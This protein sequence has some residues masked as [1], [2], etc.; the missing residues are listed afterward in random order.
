MSVRIH[1]GFPEGWAAA[2]MFGGVG[3]VGGGDSGVC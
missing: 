3:G 2:C 1:F